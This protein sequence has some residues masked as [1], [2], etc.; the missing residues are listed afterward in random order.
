VR[1]Q[2]QGPIA[3]RDFY[4]IFPRPQ[5]D[6]ARDDLRARTKR[7]GRQIEEDSRGRVRGHANGQVTICLV[8]RL[9]AKPPRDF[10]LHRRD[11]AADGPRL[12]DRRDQN[13]G[14][15][16]VGQIGDER[17]RQ[18]EARPRQ[19][20]AEALVEHIPAKNTDAVGA[21]KLFGQDLGPQRIDLDRQQLRDPGG[22][23]SGQRPISR[24]DF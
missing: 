12:L 21:G 23:R 16:V 17:G 14:G 9:G 5:F 24:P 6:D 7:A 11:G 13:R 22:D 20:I 1:G 19:P 10:S 3:E 18:P 15:D 8:A 4:R 2:D